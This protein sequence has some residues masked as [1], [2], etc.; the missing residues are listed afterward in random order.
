MGGVSAETFYTPSDLGIL[1]NLYTAFTSYKIPG[2][3]VTALK[4]GEAVREHVRDWFK[5]VW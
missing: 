3:V 2:P 4:G 1:S 5:V